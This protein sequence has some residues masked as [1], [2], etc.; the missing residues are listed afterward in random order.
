MFSHVV[1]G[2]FVRHNDKFSKYGDVC[3]KDQ[4]TFCDTDILDRMKYE[5]K[6]T[7]ILIELPF[8][9]FGCLFLQV[10]GFMV[11]CLAISAH[12]RKSLNR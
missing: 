1:T 5:Y 4:D 10:F 2:L 7:L 8:H 11:H 6:G 9:G 12:I 3:P